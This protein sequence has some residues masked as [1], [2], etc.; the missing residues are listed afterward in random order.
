MTSSPQGPSDMRAGRVGWPSK[1]IRTLKRRLS[2]PD[3]RSKGGGMGPTSRDHGPG[4]I[5]HPRAPRR[6]SLPASLFKGKS[7][8][9][10]SMM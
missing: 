9:K 3:P 5:T 7:E 8:T 2:P 1:G 6:V 4:G 10:A